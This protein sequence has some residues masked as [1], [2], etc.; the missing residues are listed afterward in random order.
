MYFLKQNKRGIFN[1][2]RK[3]MPVFEMFLKDM[4]W[5]FLSLRNYFR[6][7]NR[8]K[9]ILVYPHF[10][11]RGSTLY[12]IGKRMGYNITNKVRTKIDVAVYWEYLTFR[13]EFQYME[14]IA[15]K[16]KVVNLHSRDISKVYVDAVF[17]KVFGYSTFIDPLTYEGAFVKKNDVNAKHDGIILQGPIQKI[18][19]GFVYQLLIDNSYNNDLVEDLRVP[20]I[21]KVLDF[22]Y[23]KHRQISERFKNTTVNTVIKKSNEVFTQDE[24]ELLNSFCQQLELEYGELDVLRNKN[25]G[26]IYVVDVNNTPQ[27]P[28]AHT[29]KEAADFALDAIAEAF[30]KAF[31]H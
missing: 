1:K 28:P 21:N 6:N 25:D 26:K 14:S 27:G 15:D 2:Y 22:V 8:C 10:P 24:L 7:G 3:Q 23:V 18:E 4:N 17:K 9:T 30:Q 16:V 29:T 12:K 5:Y 11:S 13:E 19:E 31:I 20:I